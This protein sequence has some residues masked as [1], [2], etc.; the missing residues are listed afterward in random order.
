L[1]RRVHRQRVIAVNAQASYAITDGA[2]G[3]GRPLASGKTGKG[4]NRPLVVHNLKNNWR[5]VDSGKG[6]GVM[7][8]PLRR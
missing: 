2:R 6:Q 8:I 5:V 7:K 3:E 1:H 4:R